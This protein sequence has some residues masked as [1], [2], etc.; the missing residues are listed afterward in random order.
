L[1]VI[2][3]ADGNETNAA[4]QRAVSET[5]RPTMLV[6]TRQNLP[7]LEGT[8]ELA[9]EGVNKGAYI[10]S[11]AKGELDGIIIATGSEVKLALDTQDKL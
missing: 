2:R 9:Q 3:P 1:N 6:L 11:E 4:W 7:V 5:D 8:S 10:L